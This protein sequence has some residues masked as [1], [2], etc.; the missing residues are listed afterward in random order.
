[1]QEYAVKVKLT[2]TVR[3]RAPNAIVA[4]RAHQPSLSLTADAI[5]IPDATRRP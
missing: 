2:A 1:M 5:R 4:R 3:V